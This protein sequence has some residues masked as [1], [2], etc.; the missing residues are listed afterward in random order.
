M[1]NTM[2]IVLTAL[3]ALMAFSAGAQYR[4]YGYPS[5]Y[6]RMQ[7]NMERNRNAQRVGDRDSGPSKLTINLNYGISLPLGSLRDY[8]DKP[9][10]TGWN[11]QLMYDLNP[12]VSLGLGFGFYDFYQKLPRAVY[13]DKGTTISAVQ[14]RTLQLIPIQPTILFTP[15]G[16]AGKVRPYVGLGIGGALVNYTKYWGEFGDKNNKFAFSVKPMAG[17][18]V[19]FS[20]TSPLQLN[21]G[22]GYNY[23]PYS[24]NEVHNLSTVEGNVGISLHLR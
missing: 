23:V 2:K 10:F 5:P 20:P 14:S 16:D 6:Q 15:N 18:R 11:A 12:K 13:D 1:K 7:R 17:I 22:V 9:S 3:L 4:W 19:P 21:V 8:V 24:Y